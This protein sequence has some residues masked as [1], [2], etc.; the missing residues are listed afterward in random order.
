ME[1]DKK[2]KSNRLLFFILKIS[3]AVIACWFIYKQV[4]EKENLKMLAVA[5]GN[6]FITRLKILLLGGII[7][8]MI[9]NWSVE[10]WKWKMMMS[11]IEE[12]PFLKSLE[13]VFSGL[14]I[15]FFTPNRI[16]EYAGR[17]FHLKTSNRIKATLITVIE[18]LSQLLVTIVVGSVS[19]VFYLKK[20]INV[21]DWIFVAA[22]F[23]IG[24]FIFSIIWAFLE[25]SWLSMIISKFRLPSRWMKYLEVV[26]YYSYKEL[27]YVLSLALLRYFIFANQF[28]L[29]LILFDISISY[30]D[31]LILI[32]L[33][34]YTLSVIPTIALTEIGVRGA[35]ATFFL[36]QIKS[37]PLA[38]LNSTLSLWL[39]NLV[40]PALIGTVFVF[41]FNFENHGT[42]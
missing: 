14:T 21:D 6:I 15:S 19:L 37:D 10:A 35:V 22:S 34:F 30:L 1:Q 7:I 23:F 13:A 36:G 4:V 32:P 38:V 31:A 29:L 12:I 3:I 9:L 11:K 16:G 18:N 40:V 17:V 24:L 28:Y 41:L 39:I 26:G 2:N 33:I 25:V 20:F 8:L 42:G 5:Y 27:V